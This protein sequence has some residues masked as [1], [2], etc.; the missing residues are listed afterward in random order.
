MRKNWF[1][2]GV[3][4]LLALFGTLWTLQGM[5]VLTGSA[6][7]GVTLFAVLGPIVGV[8]GVALLAF[9]VYRRRNAAR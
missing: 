5:D 6:M 7:S 8:A 3:G 9:G 4:V 2:L 1:I